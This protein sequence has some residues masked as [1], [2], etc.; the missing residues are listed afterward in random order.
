MS[1][2]K[3]CTKCGTEKETSEFHNNRRGKHGV[4]SACKVCR[5]AA[6][7]VYKAHNKEKIAV[8]QRQ[9]A[10]DNK[11]KIAAYQK[12]YVTSHVEKRVQYRKEYREENIDL[13]SFRYAAYY[14]KNK[15]AICKN[16]STY[17]INNRDK[18]NALESAHRAAKEER[19][20]SWSDKSKMLNYYK[21]ARQIT[22]DTGVPHHVDH[23]VPLRGTNVS[24][25][26]V[27]W[28]LQVITAEENL[29]KS[30]KF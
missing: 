19:T 25:L 4:D 10:V 6:M 17:R 29:K 16:V 3:T 24:G 28:N 5:Y 14:Q 15:S 13:I 8:Y 23:V 21:D 26:H 2:T 12:E 11:D 7:K 18:C 22:I 9:Y 27:E 1:L 20:V 30:N